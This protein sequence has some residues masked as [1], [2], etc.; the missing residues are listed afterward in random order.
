MKGPVSWRAY[1]REVD[2]TSES[3]WVGR[4]PVVPGGTENVGGG[5]D[6]GVTPLTLKLRRTL[7]ERSSYDLHL[8]CTTLYPRFSGFDH[9]LV[10][11]FYGLGTVIFRLRHFRG[12]VTPSPPLHSVSKDISVLIEV[13]V[14]VHSPEGNCGLQSYTSTLVVS[15][16]RVLSQRLRLNRLTKTAHVTS[17]RA[18]LVSVPDEGRRNLFPR[19]GCRQTKSSTQTVDSFSRRG[20]TPVSVTEKG[21]GRWAGGVME[22]GD[23]VN[24]Y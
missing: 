8:C 3:P 21:R 22:M 17:V 23:R 13:C 7:Y 24:S 12:N 10:S 16:E 9:V 15:I 1:L 6:W 14:G 20:S 4:G 19:N 11:E 5:T 2:G 18:D